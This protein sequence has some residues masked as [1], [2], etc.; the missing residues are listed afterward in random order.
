MGRR[1]GRAKKKTGGEGG[2]LHPTPRQI[3]SMQREVGTLKGYQLDPNPYKEQVGQA[4][5]FWASVDTSF[6]GDFFTPNTPKTAK[7]PNTPL[8][9]Y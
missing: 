4:G 6:L 3:I 1:Y 9:D 7:S 2:A 5:I 8:A